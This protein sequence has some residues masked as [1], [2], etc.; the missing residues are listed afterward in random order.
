[1]IFELLSIAAG[2]VLIF[3][4]AQGVNTGME[5]MFEG[6]GR[7]S[8]LFMIVIVSCMI[9]FMP[10]GTSLIFHGDADTV[11]YDT[12]ASQ[13]SSA[14]IGALLLVS[15]LTMK[16]QR[17]L[18]AAVFAF[19]TTFMTFYAYSGYIGFKDAVRIQLLLSICFIMVLAPRSLERL[20][21]GERLDILRSVS[22][23]CVI[24][25]VLMFAGT[26]ISMV[27]AQALGV[28][29]FD[30][31]YAALA[32]VAIAVAVAE[33]ML[34]IISMRCSSKVSSIPMDICIV[35]FNSLFVLLAFSTLR[36]VEFL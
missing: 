10:L 28:E 8:C 15:L 18:I 32:I 20:E 36:M 11:L 4:G 27:Q 2:F 13:V 3:L 7:A 16:E 25:Y 29:M 9:A 22:L 12:F 1:M 17:R 33:G 24:G 21:P 5:K 34:P 6:R 23:H 14:L 31:Q 30:N 26:V 35:M 19:L